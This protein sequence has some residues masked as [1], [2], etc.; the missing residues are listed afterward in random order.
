MTKNIRQIR[1]ACISAAIAAACL[2]CGSSPEDTRLVSSSTITPVGCIDSGTRVVLGVDELQSAAVSPPPPYRHV[3]KVTT[4]SSDDARALFGSLRDTLLDLGPTD[5]LDSAWPGD[6]PIVYFAF[7]D[8]AGMKSGA[9]RIRDI[10]VGIK[11]LEAAE[12]VE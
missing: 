3:L 8:E 9:C 11:S 12:F 7:G 10:S 4:N 5:G 6:G 1:H 2:S